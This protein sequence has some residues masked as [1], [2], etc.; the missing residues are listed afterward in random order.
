M[1]NNEIIELKKYLQDLD[2][3]KRDILANKSPKANPITLS[4]ISSELTSNLLFRLFNKDFNKTK[5]GQIIDLEKDEITKIN[6]DCLLIIKNIDKVNQNN[7]ENIYNVIKYCVDNC[8][9]VIIFSSTKI[10]NLK[11]ENSI[12]NIITNGE[13]W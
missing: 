10:D 3:V 2:S 1:N 7:S 9:Q 13:I 12:I 5:K 11:V 8:I 4:N 6:T